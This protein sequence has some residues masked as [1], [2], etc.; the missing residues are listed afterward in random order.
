RV[1]SARDAPSDA[2]LVSSEPLRCLADDDRCAVM[3][4][5]LQRVKASGLGK[6][7]QVGR[8]DTL[9]I[10]DDQMPYTEPREQLHE[11]H[12]DAACA[13][14]RDLGATEDRLS[15]RPEEERL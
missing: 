6:A 1:R 4:E 15:R 13:D 14:D 8:I 7:W 5:A 9:G 2:H 11:P 3:I 10:D 12:A